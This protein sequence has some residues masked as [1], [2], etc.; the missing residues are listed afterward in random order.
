[1]LRVYKGSRGNR[2]FTFLNQEYDLFSSG[3][4]AFQE[5]VQKDYSEEQINLFISG[6]IDQS[7]NPKEVIWE[8]ES[9]IPKPWK[10]G[11]TLT[12]RLFVT[13]SGKLIRDR[14]NFLK[15]VK[16]YRDINPKTKSIIL[17]YVRK[18]LMKTKFIKQD[19]GNKCDYL[20]KDLKL[21]LP[22]G[23]ESVKD[24]DPRK[25]IKKGG[26][27]IFHGLEA[28]RYMII[29][30]YP[31]DDIEKMKT[32]ALQ[33]GQWVRTE[34]LPKGWMV[35]ENGSA[36]FLNPTLDIM[37]L[38]KALIQMKSEGV[39]ESDILKIKK[40]RDWEEHEDLPEGWLHSIRYT[41]G[42]FHYRSF[43]SPDGRAINGSNML[44]KHFKSI[45]HVDQKDMEKV[46]LIIQK[47]GWKRMNGIPDGW[48][49]KEKIESYKGET[50]ILKQFLSE[51]GDR[52]KSPKEALKYLLANN[53]P[54]NNVDDFRKTFNPALGKKCEDTLNNTHNFKDKITEAI[55]KDVKQ[56]KRPEP[57]KIVPI[58]YVEK[59][60]LPQGWM[61][62]GRHYRSPDGQA[63]K[64]LHE[65]VRAMKSK[66]YS[67]TEIDQVKRNGTQIPFMRKSNLPAGWMVA[68]MRSGENMTGGEHVLSRYLSPEGRIFMNRASTIQ[69][70]LENSYPKN[71]IEVMKSLLISEDNW[72]IDP[73]LPNGWMTKQNKAS[74]VV[75]LAPTWEILNSK[76]KVLEYMKKHDYNEAVIAEAKKYLYENPKFIFY[77]KRI[78]NEP[79]NEDEELKPPKK[80]VHLDPEVIEWK[81]GDSSVP[82]NWLIATKS[83]NSILISSPKGEKFSSRIEAIASMIKNQQSPGDIFRMWK[84]LHLEGWVCD[85]ENLPSG[86]RRKYLEELGT[87]HYLSPLMVVI[88]TTEALLKHLESSQEYSSEDIVKVKLWIDSL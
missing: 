69:F 1:M 53:Y 70:M 42:K 4:Q 37:N 60:F 11:K 5:L 22:D 83:D 29:D 81:S 21:D 47:D 24:S 15:F 26:R 28:V 78:K 58:Q 76:V 72:A 62:N 3:F 87:Y 32:I 46:K 59:N 6:F 85:E 17:A 10:I 50:R 73:I 61:T 51:K 48:N 43:L 63:F 20:S 74:S 88:K 86:W 7:I 31:M 25:F 84:N 65:T 45:D 64:N 13:P 38:D 54:K 41:S 82:E 79:D 30:N 68:I 36:K 34:Y 66:G 39:T 57:H 35:K 2:S 77:T 67:E 71:D 33:G 18:K 40:G 80:K 56:K 49:F 75:F 19:A 23:W 16:N 8:N 52:L 44:L 14:N 9:V 55:T 27:K 12:R